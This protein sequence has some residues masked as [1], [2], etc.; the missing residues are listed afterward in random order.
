[1]HRVVVS[2]RPNPPA[3]AYAAVMT[4]TSIPRMLT[5]MAAL[6][7]AATGCSAEV[8]PARPTTATVNTSQLATSDSPT[9]SPP[10]EDAPVAAPAPTGPPVG[11]ATMEIH[12]TGAGPVSIRYRINDGPEQVETDVALPWT[13]DY[14]VYNEL[15]SSVTAEGGG[16][17]VLTCTIIMDEMLLSFVSEPNPTCTF[18]YWG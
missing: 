6:V 11:T 5:T 3:L 16:D 14:P 13:I 12:G 18:A 2:E 8:D 17:T 4:T 15:T 9:T 10:V 1:M 7:T